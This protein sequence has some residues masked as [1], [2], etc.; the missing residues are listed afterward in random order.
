MMLMVTIES[1]FRATERHSREEN[2]HFARAC[3]RFAIDQKYAPFASHLLY[4]QDGILD[5]DEKDQRDLGIEMGLMWGAR[6]SEI[7]FCVREGEKISE[8]MMKAMNFYKY[9]GKPIQ[10]IEFDEDMNPTW[11]GDIV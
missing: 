9:I 6:A 10:M 11:Q 5:D 8:G 3:C 2:I 4:T 1:P 7:W